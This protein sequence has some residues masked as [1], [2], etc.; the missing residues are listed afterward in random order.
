MWF[1]LALFALA[2]FFFSSV[3]AQT[4]TLS[5]RVQDGESRT[6]V[7]GATVILRSISDTTLS[8]TSYTDTAGLFQFDQLAPDSFRLTISSVGFEALSRSVRVDSADV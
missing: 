7:Q 1:R 5:G 4:F 2:L 6:A 8:F 3:S